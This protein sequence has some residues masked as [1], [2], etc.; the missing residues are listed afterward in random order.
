MSDVFV[1]PIGVDEARRR[2]PEILNGFAEHTRQDPVVVGAYRRPQG[3]IISF[4]EYQEHH[5]FRRA[6][7]AAAARAEATAESL[8]SV[9]AEGLEPGGEAHLD[10]DA[11]VAGRLTADELVQRAVA[12]HRHD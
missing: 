6:Q 4:E 1:Q 8:G 7:E 12:R 5:E 9:R 2:L 10:A 11:Y 3:V